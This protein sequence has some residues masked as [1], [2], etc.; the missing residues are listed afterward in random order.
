MA[1]QD[2]PK[3]LFDV[4][5]WR[6]SRAI[7]RMSMAERGVYFEML[8]E[9][10][11][12]RNLPDSVEAVADA[13]AT[14]D[15]Q[16]AEVVAAWPVVRRKFITSRGDSTRIYNETME[17][18]RRKQRENRREKQVAGAKG[19]KVAAAN[20]GKN[21]DLQASS[22]TAL[23]GPA[24][25]KHSEKEEEGKEV[26][27]VDVVRSEEGGKIPRPPVPIDGR[28]KRP[29][30]AGQRLTVFEWMFDECC[31]LLGPHTD[32]FFLDDWFHALDASCVSDGVIPPRRDNGEWLFAQLMAEARRRGLNLRVASMPVMGKQTT[33]LAAALASIKAAE[34]V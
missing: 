34:A 7:Q 9:Q 19:G 4:A 11:E 29:I 33:K 17:R 28:S 32:G 12:K 27:K 13:I 5:G 20:R 18:T 8:L 10:W 21:K 22:A 15:A 23:L 3:F 25:A 30:F 26:E 6:G 14:T 2:L 31:K 24:T 1:D 16:I